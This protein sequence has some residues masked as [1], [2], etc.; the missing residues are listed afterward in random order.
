MSNSIARIT[1][2][3]ALIGAVVMA[4]PAMAR[5]G[6]GPGQGEDRPAPPA[7]ADCRAPGRNLAPVKAGSVPVGGLIYI[8]G[9]GR[10]RLQGSFMSW[11]T[12]SG[13]TLKVVDRTGDG[14]AKVAGK[15]VRF[16]PSGG[17]ERSA[18]ITSP[19]GQILVDGTDIRMEIRGRGSL[20]ISVTG[21]G[22][23]DLYGVGTFTVNSGAPKSWP[24]DTIDLALAPTS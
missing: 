15:C 11:G 10:V 20:A 23:G 12:V 22:T 21:S 2:C 19:R 7:K 18:T 17:R 13:M 14:L 24:L 9:S 4:G 16:R 5:Q 1:A 8:E 6:Q 3:A